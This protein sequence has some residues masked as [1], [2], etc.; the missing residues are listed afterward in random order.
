MTDDKDR[1][2]VSDEKMEDVA[3][4]VTHTGAVDINLKGTKKDKRTGASRATD[5]NST[6]SNNGG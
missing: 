4:G 2:K 6:R 5:H 1:K 3:G